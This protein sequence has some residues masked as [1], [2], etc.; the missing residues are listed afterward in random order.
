MQLRA[1]KTGISLGMTLLEWDYFK[2]LI[3]LIWNEY[4]VSDHPKEHQAL[5]KLIEI[6]EI[7]KVAA[8]FER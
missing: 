8:N 2:H 7:S 6:P 5:S 3:S 1:T 4:D